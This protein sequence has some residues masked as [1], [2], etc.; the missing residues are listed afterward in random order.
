M[1]RPER[2]SRVSVTGSKRVMDDAIEAIHGLDLL[3]VTDYD[4]TWEGFDP[5]D[6]VEGADEAAEKLVTVRA[7]Q[8][9]LGVTEADAGQ[10]RIIPDDE[11]DAELENVRQRVNELDD[12]R[13]EL[14]DELREI[15]DAIDTARPFAE[16]GIDIDLFA[17]YDSLT[18]AVGE[19]DAGE[20]RD[21][22]EEAAAIEAYEL[23]EGGEYVGVFVYPETDLQEALVGVSFTEYEIPETDDGATSPEAYIDQLRTRRER[24]ESRLDGVESDLEEVGEEVASFLFAAEEK[25]AIEVQKREAPLTFA[26]TDNAFIAEGW[27]PTE[28]RS[29]MED[30][31]EAAVGDH[32]ELEEL[33]RAAYD[34]EGHAH[35]RE[36]VDPSDPAGPGPAEEVAADGGTTMST[37]APPVIQDNG[38]AVKPF[39]SLI[40]VINRPKYSELDP[41]LILFLT[42]PL[43]FG[44]MI[45]D[46]GYGLLYMGL[47]YLIMRRFES[48][49]VRSLGGVGVY[50]GAFTVVFGVLYGEFFGL[51]QLG[52]IVWGGN[53]PIHKGLQPHFIYYAYAWLLA[54]AVAGVAHLVVGRVFDFVNNLEHGVGEAFMESGS[55]IV[56]TVGTWWWVF[57]ATALGPKPNFMF[58]VFAAEGMTNPAT[59]ETITEGVAL[60]LGFNGFSS[61]ELFALPVIGTV[62]LQILTILV[63]LALVLRVEG[64]IGLVES[65]TQAFGHVVSYTRIAAVLLAKA[66][67]ALAVNLLVFGAYLHDGEFHLIFF[68]EAAEI[69]EA[70]AANEVIFG[71]LLNAD[72]GVMLAL[73]VLFGVVVLVL[74][75]VL[76]L[77]LGITSAGLQAIR[78]EYVEFFGK[79][80]EGGGKKYTPFG[81]E[82]T[83]TT[84]D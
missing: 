40:E 55:W 3:H 14:E 41:T 12:E 53:P 29:E 64:A 70:Q 50:A 45:G 13:S 60:P 7:L 4:G 48:G 84:E 22:L 80:Y 2:M 57:T 28:R 8:S 31:L 46:V 17:G 54:S 62:S 83:Y 68:A 75:H 34:G 61:V 33:E 38:G 5:G 1:L 71:G 30:A 77:V 66:G 56:L 37:S 42:F 39:E 15:D 51:H 79:F 32:V 16:L 47:G 6:P 10:P 25:L 74:G 59:G 69:S 73:G 26:T 81:H 27:I 76:V 24:V 20:I 21:A 67:M 78:L 19:G 72:G 9:T 43:F 35:D 82:R 44:F 11:L 18:A 52:E 58:S 63:G 23:F 49:A 65:I 36:S